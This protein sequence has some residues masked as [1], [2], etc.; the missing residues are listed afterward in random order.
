[1][2]IERFRNKLSHS[3]SE[4]IAFIEDSFESITTFDSVWNL[5]FGKLKHALLTGNNSDYIHAAVTLG[6]HLQYC[7]RLGAWKAELQP[8]TRLRWGHWLLPM[9]DR[10]VVEGQKQKVMIQLT[11]ADRT[12]QI[13]FVQ[14]DGK[15]EGEGV[16]VLPQTCKGL[17]HLTLLLPNTLTDTIFDDLRPDF[18]DNVSVK[19]SLILC[20]SAGELLRSHSEAY[21]LWVERVIHSIVPLKMENGIILNSSIETRPGIVGIS[22]PLTVLALVETLIHEAAHQHFY[23]LSRLGAVEDGTDTTLY[24]SPIKRQERPIR[25][26]L[27]AYHAFANVVLFYRICRE[28]NFSESEACYQR[29]ATLFPQLIQLETALQTS[30]SL[31]PLGNSLWEP[32]AERIHCGDV[33]TV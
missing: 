16:E 32:L 4:L 29:E 25:Y 33:V 28:N 13:T 3:H 17:K 15:W 18:G 27:I 31:T 10:L 9:A 23:L 21:F 5:A 22:L 26:I 6:L 2:F 24:Y 12:N 20:E 1:V 30:R 14:C 7:G 19:E 8:S 11:H